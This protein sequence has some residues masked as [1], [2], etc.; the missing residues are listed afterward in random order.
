MLQLITFNKV[1]GELEINLNSIYYVPDIAAIMKRRSPSMEDIVGTAKILNKKELM[2]VFY[3]AD[4][5]STNYLQALSDEDR[6]REAKREARLAPEWTPDVI[7]ATV[8][9]KY[10][11][12]QQKYMPSARMLIT[13]KKGLYSL[14]LYYANLEK[15]N[16]TLNKRLDMLTKL[17]FSSNDATTNIELLKETEMVNGLLAA[18]TK[19]ILDG[20]S[21]L[22]KAHNDITAFEKKVRTEETIAAE[23]IGGGKPYR[24]EVPKRE[25]SKI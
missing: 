18:N 15:Q 7:V 10:I 19:V 22:E 23:I 1:T 21:K 11:A 24:R 5:T 13:L 14:S 3:M 8:I 20:I 2:Y 4:W 25:N 16:S 17:A 9:S 12:I 6:D